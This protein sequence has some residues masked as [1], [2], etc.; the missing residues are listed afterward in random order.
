MLM[1]QVLLHTELLLQPQDMPLRTG[2][3]SFL[4]I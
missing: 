4:Y 3:E 1:Q 2:V